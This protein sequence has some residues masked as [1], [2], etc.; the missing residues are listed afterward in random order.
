MTLQRT[1]A[2][3]QAPHF[4]FYNGGET[5]DARQY[6]MR[7]SQHN[8]NGPR[9]AAAV[10]GMV[11]GEYRT[12]WADSSGS[13]FSVF[14]PD[15]AGGYGILDWNWFAYWDAPTQQLVL[16]GKR[17]MYKLICYS[18]LV[19]DWRQLPMPALMG[20]AGGTGHWYGVT[21][22]DGAGFA[23]LKDYRYDLDSETGE[24]IAPWN[25]YSA[26]GSLTYIE[27]QDKVALLLG[28]SIRVYDRASNTW[29][30][31]VLGVGHGW[32]V[33]AAYNPV[34]DRI[35][36]VGG[37]YTSNRAS[38][39]TVAGVA[40][41]VADVPD[42]TEHALGSWVI[43]HPSGCWIVKTMNGATKKVY[44]AWPNEARTAVTWVDLGTAP[45]AGL[46]Y[47]AVAYDADRDM[48][49]LVG[50]TGLYAWK[51]PTL[52]DPG[53]VAADLPGSYSVMA[54]VTAELP[55]AYSV[56]AAAQT[57]LLGGYVVF[58]SVSADLSGSYSVEAEAGT[59]SA[60]M[61]GGYAVLAAVQAD[62]AGAYSVEAPGTV[63]SDLLGGY[64]V[65]G[66]VQRD[67]V[68]SYSVLGE[69]IT[70]TNG[71]ELSYHGK[72]FRVRF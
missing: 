19:G 11:P 36:A 15:S 49:L 3:S 7:P 30:A 47:P 22:G 35:L 63:T 37:T 33:M 40:T 57:D 5:A 25:A 61:L 44:A 10:S 55:G 6:W 39:V 18:D 23:Y 53:T 2:L 69:T 13:L 27:G 41:Q 64:S 72:P 59:V 67:L 58:G 66:T 54:A 43:A 28:N 31:E 17:I 21:A 4:S 14:R 52:S 71:Y 26:V 16:G 12:V 68:G 56:L 42:L 48:A 8:T 65:L 34:V 46:T 45:D 1:M 29:S 70:F 24:L 32:H 50:T 51:L 62:L 9:I 60:D 20:R 38:L